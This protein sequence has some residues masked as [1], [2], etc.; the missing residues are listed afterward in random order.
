ML[1]GEDWRGLLGIHRTRPPRL[2]ERFPSIPAPWSRSGFWGA[3]SAVSDPW[4]T[5][6]VAGF[7]AYTASPRA[8]NIVIRE[9]VT[10][11]FGESQTFPVREAASGIEQLSREEILR[12]GPLGF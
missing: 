10:G 2:R 3:A 1:F 9:E 8:E 5:G 6:R 12:G 11:T 4:P 7:L